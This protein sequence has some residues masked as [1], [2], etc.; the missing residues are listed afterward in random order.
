MDRLADL[1]RLL[2][3]AKAAGDEAEIAKLERKIAACVEAEPAAL[4]SEPLVK[5][6]RAPRKGKA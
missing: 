1:N 6:A 2:N 3:L 5:P 4:P